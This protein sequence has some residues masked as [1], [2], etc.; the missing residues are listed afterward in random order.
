VEAVVTRVCI[1]IGR[2]PPDF[3]GHA[4]QVQRMLPHLRALGVEPTVVA[5]AP[6]AET[7]GAIAPDAAPVLR[8]LA[9]ERAPLAKTRHTL[10]LFHHFLHHA[11]DYDLVHT[12]L[13]GWELFLNVPWIQRRGLPILYEM[14]LLGTDDPVTV[15]R[16]RFGRAKLALLSRADAWVGITEAF[17]P[18][19]PAA[20][21][22]EDRF[23]CIYG[24]V[25][26]D[27]YRP[28]TADERRAARAA[29]DLPEDA[30]VLV[31]AGALVPRKGMDRVLRAWA[32]LRPT[33][34]R[35]VL[36]LVG[37]SNLAEG[38]PPRF[39]DHPAELRALAAAAGVEGTVRFAGRVGDLERWY[40][41]ADV[42]AF[43]SHREGQ[44]YVI[45]E[46]MASGLPCVVS[47]LGG[48]GRELVA[49]GGLV[50]DDPDDADAVAARIGEL[51]ADPARRRALG[52]RV[53]ARAVERF[54]MPARARAFADVYRELVEERGARSRRRSPSSRR[55]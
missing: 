28:F 31:S 14:V 12:I 17:R 6:A 2:Y 35:D 11:G 32:R 1:L 53:R 45:V 51:L 9:P 41:A 13:H 10:E 26:T 34:G 38:L 29:L 55:R 47:S 46:A 4:I 49:D 30:R 43:L 54:S 23:R 33:P 16:L 19:L 7:A 48:I 37:P 22:A 18:T 44:G 15:S 39:A 24:G 5:Y 3:S 8:V 36:L 25:D 20:G 21:I 52:E 42:F 27:R 50:A 40:G